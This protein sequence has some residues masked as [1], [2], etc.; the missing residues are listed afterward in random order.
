MPRSDEAIKADLASKDPERIAA[1]LRDLK[2]RMKAGSNLELA[3]FG[4]EIL[5][6]FGASVPIETQLDLLAILNRYR[7]FAPQLSRE[8]RIAGM[9]EIVLRYAEHYVA[10]EVALLLKISEYPAQAVETA[11]R[12]IV[13]HGLDSPQHV[14]GAKLLVSRLLD[15]KDEVRRA[16]LEALR[17]WPQEEPYQEVA[18]YIEPQLDPVEVEFLCGA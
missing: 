14:D 16:T 12:H 2:D 1:G 5:D 9:V 8:Q 6:P 11:M 15:G 13:C 4:P 17:Q 3:P 18:K 10:Y 7:A